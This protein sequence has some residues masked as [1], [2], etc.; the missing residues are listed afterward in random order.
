MA[1]ET[2]FG[3][4][5]GSYGDPRRYMNKQ[6]PAKKIEQAVAKIKN[7]PLANIF[8]LALAGGGEQK[9]MPPSIPALGQGIGVPSAPSVGIKP[10]APSVVGI[11][12]ASLQGPDL[13]LPQVASPIA[14]DVDLDNDGQI[15]NFWGLNK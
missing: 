1:T 14:Q 5:F 10:N 3:L 15:D 11:P 12:P 13:S 9:T 7:S 4:S 6:P 8:G 2:P